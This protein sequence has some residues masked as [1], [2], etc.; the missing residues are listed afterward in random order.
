M[1]VR[2]IG[3]KCRCN[4][5]QIANTL[6]YPRKEITKIAFYLSLH[7]CTH[8]VLSSYGWNSYLL[9]ISDNEKEFRVLFL[10]ALSSRSVQ[11]C[12]CVC[13][14]MLDCYATTAGKRWN[15]IVKK[16]ITDVINCWKWPY[17]HEM[18]I[19]HP[20]THKILLLWLKIYFIFFLFSFFGP[21]HH[22]S[23]QIKQIKANR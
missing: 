8:R 19:L 6:L 16:S 17:L 10:Y 11:V 18:P 3:G 4:C 1:P 2:H 21:K 15:I 14:C 13:M 23:N 9:I 5:K 12:V 20:L 7:C 22:T